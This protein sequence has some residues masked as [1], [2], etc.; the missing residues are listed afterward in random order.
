MRLCL[1]FVFGTE[2]TAGLRGKR[3]ALHIPG[4]GCATGYATMGGLGKPGAGSGF[5]G[6]G[7]SCGPGMSGSGGP[8]GGSSGLGGCGMG[9]SGLGARRVSLMR[10]LWCSRTGNEVNAGFVE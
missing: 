3:P 6:N 10:E 4:T 9:S 8:C 2:K 7:G 1:F 5:P